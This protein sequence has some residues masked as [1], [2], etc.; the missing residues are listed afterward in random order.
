MDVCVIGLWH[1][2]IVG[3]AC[4]ADLGYSVFAADHDGG[5]VDR[6]NDGRAPL[7]EP[8]L[9][10]LIAAGLASGR[11]RFDSD[12]AGSVVGRPY[13]LLTTATRATS[14]RSWPRPGKSPRTW[15]TT[16]SCT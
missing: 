2:G 3:A 4:L 5:K 12:V 14:P 15:P 9:D 11:L 7:Y 13:V 16:W 10:D 6:L 8:G 1:Q